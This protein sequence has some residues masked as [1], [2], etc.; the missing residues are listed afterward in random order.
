MK[1]NTLT[2]KKIGE[3]VLSPWVI[4]IFIF[5]GYL[6]PMNVLAATAHL[7]RCPEFFSFFKKSYE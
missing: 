1:L 2:N 7:N 3:L 4:G 6:L 5:L